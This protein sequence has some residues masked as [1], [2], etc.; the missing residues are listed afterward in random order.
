MRLLS[1]FAVLLL[2][3]CSTQ[4]PPPVA[5]T[6]VSVDANVA[7]DRLAEEYFEESLPLS[8]VFATSIGDNRY[9]DRYTAS[10]SEEQRAASLALA[11]K[12]SDAARRIDTAAL[13]ETHRVSH[14]IFTR[15]LANAIEGN[16]YPFHLAPVDQF[17]NFTA[18]FAQMGSGTGLHPFKTVKDYDDFL[19]RMNGFT[20]AV[21]IAI[22]NMRRGMAQGI[23]V[24]RALVEKF[25]PQLAAHVV[26]DPKTSIFYGPVKNFPE[27]FSSADRARLTA[28]YETAIGE[29]LVAAYR[30]LHDFVR[31]QYLPKARAT[32][33]LSALP[34]GR[35]WYEYLVRVSTTTNLTADQIHDIGLAEVARIHREMEKVK[36]QVGFNGDLKA[37]FEF[38]GKDPRFHFP[39]RE[40]MLA[41][42]NDAKI[43]IDATT[44]RLFDVQPKAD[45]EIRPVEA[46]RE[47]SAAGGSYQPASPDGSRPGIF[48][49]NTYN[50][51]SRHTW[52]M[53]SL[54]LHEG[55]PGHHFQL[56]IQRELESL[57]RFRRF[58]GYTAYS[59]G[60]GLYAESLGKELGVYQDPY[61]YYGALS[62]EL[63][64]AIRLVLDTG[65]H[66]KG[67]T[68][69][70]AIQYALANSSQ[71]EVT[72]T[73]EVERF[74]AIPGQALSYKIGQMKISELRRRAEQALGSRFD[75]KAFH[76]AI[77]E[78][79]ALPLDV[80]EEKIDRWIA[81]GGSSS[82]G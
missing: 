34:G 80:L 9:N 71:S 40:A 37:F 64:R 67:W 48:Y 14:A 77:L 56:S 17:R 27:T 81:A 21:D 59:E 3:A 15:N 8:P 26:S 62:G 53:E 41:A 20:E 31:D 35:E 2:V 82:R 28:A 13:D 73:I 43:R 66:A 58:G 1:S 11:Q 32:S 79:G 76:R 23:V 49:V 33:G 25:I 52:A 18:Q 68:R 72:A 75:I 70:Q 29:R 12:Y 57:P 74:M 44:S 63:W 6:P 69:E 65:I 4:T 24:P 61:Q 54:L 42:Y 46:F 47:Q 38:V 10:F 7:F 50:L 39:S 55:S 45:Y 30:R 60:W 36:E 16:R 19:S 5:S 22:A 51:P 78:D